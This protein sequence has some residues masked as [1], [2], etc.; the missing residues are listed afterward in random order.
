M[1]QCILL[2]T[3]KLMPQCSLLDTGKLMPAVY[4]FRQRQINAPIS[5]VIVPHLG[6]IK[7]SARIYYPAFLS[8]RDWYSSGLGFSFVVES[9]AAL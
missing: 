9:L 6:R 8:G 1:P 3:G 5:I 4:F 2:D 7:K